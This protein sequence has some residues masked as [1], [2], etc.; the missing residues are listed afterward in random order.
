ML[1]SE[2]T[3]NGLRG[4]PC[5]Q[6]KGKQRC[7][8]TLSGP[9]SQDYGEQFPDDVSWLTINNSTVDTEL[10]INVRNLVA[11]IRKS[12]IIELL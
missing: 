9:V 3:E 12:K 2:N 4:K 5:T 6:E 10:T 11:K 1:A 7:K 8:A